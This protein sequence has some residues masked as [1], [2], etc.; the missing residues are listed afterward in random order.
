[1]S[2]KGEWK[3]ALRI[4]LQNMEMG[5]NALGN[6]LGARKNGEKGRKPKKVKAAAPR[7]RHVPHSVV[8]SQLSQRARLPEEGASDPQ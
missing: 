8:T 1:M 6:T 7:Q 5:K 4:D 2:H 3:E